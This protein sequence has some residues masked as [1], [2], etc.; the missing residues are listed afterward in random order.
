MLTQAETL[1]SETEELINSQSDANKYTIYNSESY[2][3]AY[4]AMLYLR[5]HVKPVIQKVSNGQ[6]VTL[7]RI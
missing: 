1:W 2:K 5:N 4:A 7:S 6:A 3:E